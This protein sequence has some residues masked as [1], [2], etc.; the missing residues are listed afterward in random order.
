MKDRHDPG[1]DIGLE[2]RG[3]NRSVNV[4]IGGRKSTP[5]EAKYD[6]KENEEGDG[7]EPGKQAQEYE[8]RAA[9]EENQCE[10]NVVAIH[11]DLARI[12]AH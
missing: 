4:D 3:K 2:L 5:R 12:R 9:A 6:E 7:S 10:L 8:E 11:H 1:T